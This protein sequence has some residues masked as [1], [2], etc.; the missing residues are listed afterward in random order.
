MKIVSRRTQAA[1]A[2]L[3]PPLPA[4]T[5]FGVSL[6]SDLLARF[7][8]LVRERGLANRSEALRELIRR[9]FVK[10]QW[11]GQGEV[12]GA[13]T[14]VYDHHRRDLVSRLTDVQHD[15][16]D[17]ILSSQH[18]HLDHH[19]CLEIV[20]V[21]GPARAVR[22]LSDSLKAVKGVMHG[23]LSMSSTGRDMP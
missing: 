14:L 13:V 6:E 5:R 18:V 10:E 2:L 17:V 8:R 12:A 22:R 1:P 7:D 15:H 3:E 16:A 11:D 9:E 20:A 23:T 21:R 4:L 19:H